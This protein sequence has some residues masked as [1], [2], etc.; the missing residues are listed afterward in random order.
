VNK[1]QLTVILTA[2]I[3]TIVIIVGVFLFMPSIGPRYLHPMMMGVESGPANLDT[4]TSRLSDAGLYRVSWRSDSD[5]VPLNQ[6]HTWTLRVETADGQ[7][8]EN[9]VILVDGGMPQHGHGLPTSPKVTAYLGDG[10]YRVEGLRFQMP[11]FWVMTFSISAD[12]QSDSITFNL[13]LE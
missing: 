6:I 10:E 11:G 2:A 5:R 13:I 12:G 3:T 8:V 9:A 7:P 4:S 1:Q